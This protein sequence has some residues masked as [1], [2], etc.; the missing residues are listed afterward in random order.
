MHR[1]KESIDLVDTLQLCQLLHP[2]A[3]W[4]IH[5]GDSGTATVPIFFYSEASVYCPQ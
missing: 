4:E 1:H 3:P 5:S 2:C